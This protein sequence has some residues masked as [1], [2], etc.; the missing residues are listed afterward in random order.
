MRFRKGVARADDRTHTAPAWW[1]YARVTAHRPRAGLPLQ[2]CDA[3]GPVMDRD[4]TPYLCGD[5]WIA[6][7]RRGSPSTTRRRSSPSA[8]RGSC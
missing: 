4:E 8:R 5:G 2:T 1:E 7:Y 3:R 6:H